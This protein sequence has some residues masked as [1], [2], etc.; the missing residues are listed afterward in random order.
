MGV[1]QFTSMGSWMDSRL[2]HWDYLIVTA[3][4]DSQADAYERQLRI[5]QELGLL[6]AVDEWLVVPDPDGRRIGSGGSTL[7]CLL[8]LLNR[9]LGDAAQSSGPADWVRVLSE[10]RVLIIHAGGDAR[11]LP[12]YGPCGKIFVPVPGQS[13]RATC[14]TLFDRQLPVFLAL[15]GPSEGEGQ[16][17][18]T[19]GD[20]M[21]RFDPAGVKFSASGITGLSCYSDP[22]Q[23]AK[24]G[25]F[26]RAS[27]GQ[28]RIF[29][30]KP[31]VAEQQSKGA[32]DAYGQASLDVGVSNLDAATAVTLLVA[33]GA[34]A[35]DEALSLTGE[36]G[37]AVVEKGVDFYREIC[38]AMG[39]ETTCEQYIGVAKASGSKWSD[40]L[41]SQLFETFSAVPFTVPL[42]KHCEFLEFGNCRGLIDGG[43]RLLQD[44]RGVSHLHRFLDV[45]NT[46]S[47]EGSVQGTVSWV[48]GCRISAPLS[49]GGEN[50]VV[51][52]DVDAPLSLQSRICLDVIEGRNCD[53]DRVWFVKIYGIDDK[54]KETIEQGGG[55]CGIGVTDWLEAVGASCEDVWDDEVDEASRSMWNA[56][57]F[58]AVKSHSEFADW[59][60]MGD[61]AA[62]T[63]EQKNTWLKADRYSHEQILAKA[64]HAEFYR[65]RNRIRSRVIYESLGRMFRPESG[66]SAAELAYLLRD[67][68]D[69]SGWISS[70]L[71]EAHRHCDGGIQGTASLAFPRIMHTLGSAISMA[72]EGQNSKAG[73]AFEGVERRLDAAVLDRLES[74]GLGI[75]GEVSVEQWCDRAR[76]AAFEGLENAIVSSGLQ[77]QDYPRSVLRADEIVWAR[78]PARLDVGGGWTDTPPYSLEH[79]GCVINAAVDL[80][81]QPPIQAY[82]RVT[83]EPAIRIGSIDLGVSVRIDSFDGLLDYR[84]A[85]SSFALAKAALALSGLSPGA[86]GRKDVSLKDVLNEFG[87]G[88]ELTTLA[89]IPKGSG[90]G[91]SSIMGAVI[92]AAIQRCMGREL[93]QRQ[94]WHSVLRLE[95]SLTTG[96]G[97][98]DQI[99]GVV[100]GVKLVS[101]EPGLIPDARIHY[102]PC[103]IIDPRLNGG[104]T[105]LYYTGVTRLAKNILHQ[106]VGRYLDRDRENLRTLGNIGSFAR[107]V[108]EAFFCKDIERFGKLTDVVWRLNKQLDPDSTNEEVEGIFERV[109]KYIWGGKLLG[110]GGGGFLLMVCKSPEAAGRIRTLLEA[111]PPNERARFFD[112]N[113]SDSGLVVTV[114]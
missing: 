34:G 68:N 29:L 6:G 114:S 96:G 86:A 55:F 26:C 13:D 98:Q 59:L 74:L 58:P 100:D 35:D 63:D 53:D 54:L 8:E 95:Q 30:Q 111:E 71:Q 80:N 41:L 83:R 97:W 46:F 44:E 33:F 50:I 17:V 99:G 4:N 93:S 2:G 102:V 10:L 73:S 39:T 92:L 70:I 32:I 103:D 7:F 52:V 3:S 36:M 28:L 77:A 84:Q 82:L 104:R 31:S 16:V 21:L 25:V 101:A 60:W 47:G 11:R 81:G 78:A 108:A 45:N 22:E 9:R 109:R 66:F 79:G 56:R 61:V 37:R 38:C 113:V 105:L 90:L 85:T 62:A 42:V 23:A 76:E 88:I 40:E 75:D 49:L 112:F 87:G 27:D 5:R 57:M 14:L 107:E 91:T 12:A 43:T 15:P 67:T 94:L 106:V 19:S 110:A 18:I 51:G 64:E 72:L 89:A 48:E 24:H 65:R 69:T 1:E 20:V